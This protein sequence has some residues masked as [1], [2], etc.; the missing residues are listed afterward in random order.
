MDIPL[1]FRD[2]EL[3]SVPLP[4]SNN[5]KKK[6]EKCILVTFL[7]FSTKLI[8]HE[9]QLTQTMRG[10]GSHS[11]KEVPRVCEPGTDPT[12]LSQE[13]NLAPFL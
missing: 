13:G 8:P 12:R 9:E 7:E 10:D 5:N 1:Q 3:E 4:S 2:G 11:E 6:Q